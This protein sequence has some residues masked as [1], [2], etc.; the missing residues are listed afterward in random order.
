VEHAQRDVMREPLWEF[1]LALYA[2]PGVPEACL[3]LQ[4]RHGLDVNLVLACLWA[5]ASGRG[6]LDGARIAALRDAS[7]AWQETVV[8]PLRG[9]RRRLKG[10]PESAFREQ[11]KAL[12]LEAERIEQRLLAAALGAARRGKGTRA[13]AEATLAALIAAHDLDPGE[14][15]R[16]RLARLVEGAFAVIG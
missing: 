11:V 2:R 1:S 10:W 9:I 13:D 16:R 6:R 14:A 7:Q 5:A 15:D 12:E 8:A 4:D 3:A